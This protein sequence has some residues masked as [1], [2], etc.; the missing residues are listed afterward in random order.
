MIVHIS[1]IAL[2]RAVYDQYGFNGLKNGVP[3]RDGYS[4]FKGQYKFHGDSR[5]V[6]SEFFG[7]VNPFED[8]FKEHY[9]HPE[10][11][12]GSK[13]GGMHGM[14]KAAN[15]EG[16]Q[17]SPQVVVDLPLTL[18][19]LYN[20]TVKKITI[21][22]KILSDDNATT[23]PTTSTLT[24]PITKGTLSGTRLVFPNDGSESPIKLPSDRVFKITQIP[25]SRFTRTENDLKHTCKVSLKDALC[26]SIVVVQT[27]DD[28]ILRIAVDDVV[29]PGF[30]KVVKGEG[31][32][33]KNGGQGDLI[34]GFNVV[35]PTN[36]SKEKKKALAAA[37]DS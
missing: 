21:E 25:H 26:G 34:L 24:I 31:M 3:S 18:E 29:Y 12:F 37:F 15:A 30:E 11:L 27:L 16:P 19:E 10:A 32:P 7:S 28:R 2:K 8:F 1:N 33:N 35:F 23:I 17:Q 14:A 20:G 5:K 13:F 6:F 9:E 4:G 36:V 22:K